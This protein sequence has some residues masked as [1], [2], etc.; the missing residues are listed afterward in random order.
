MTESQPEHD[1]IDEPPPKWPRLTKEEI[2]TRP[3]GRYEGPIHVI[4]KP[5]QVAAA[6][7][8]LEQE[9]LLGFDTETRPT[10]RSGQHYQP[11]VLQ[12]ASRDAVF[13][14]QIKQCHF[15]RGLRRLLSNPDIIKA[16]V[17]LDRDIK[18]LN[19]IAVFQP[20]G[21]V[22]VAD[23]AKAAGCQNHGL[24][25][26]AAC[27][28]GFRISKRSQVSNWAQPRLTPAQIDYAA[29]DAWVGRKL[30]LKLKDL[31]A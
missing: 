21:F 30:Y 18:E 1:H 19:E 14:F 5:D 31:G 9:T 15:G 16:G 6:L 29:T 28:L 20:G 25:N 11:T 17:A 2:N 26:L 3:I 8:H 23:L 7:E 24:R 27:L 4:R 13:V 12:L 10:F 22:D